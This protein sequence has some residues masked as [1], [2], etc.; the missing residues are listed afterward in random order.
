MGSCSVCYLCMYLSSNQ[1]PALLSARHPFVGTCGPV[2][3][4]SIVQQSFSKVQPSFSKVL[5]FYNFVRNDKKQTEMT[6]S[7][8]YISIFFGNETVQSQ[9]ESMCCVFER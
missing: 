7:K 1:P 4:F 9:I 8:V 3:H 2:P 5:Q 6:R